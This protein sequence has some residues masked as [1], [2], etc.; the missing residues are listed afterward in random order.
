MKRRQF[1]RYAGAGVLT[2]AGT[3]VPLPRKRAFGQSQG[4]LTVTGFGHT[5]FFLPGGGGRVLVNPFRAIGC[6]KGYRVPNVEADLVLISSQLFDEGATENLPG[7]PQILFEPG[8]FEVRNLQFQ[9]I[10]SDRDRGIGRRFSTNVAWRWTQAG[11]KI[12]HLGGTVAPIDIEQQILMGRPDLAFMPV[13][14][15]PKAYNPE[16]AMQ[17]LRA[18]RPKI[19]VP[20]HYRTQAADA[21]ACDLVGIEEF[22]QLAGDI[23][24]VRVGDNR[25]SLSPGNFNRDETVI[26]VLDYRSRN[27]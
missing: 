15:G 2:A 11:V 17:A 16:E 14:G 10:E 20:T 26:R 24:V 8:A 18:L 4:A 3:F 12:L 9:G 5:C 23:P 7:N 13:G 27:A 1:I 19:V 6:T 22:L 25:M 21:N